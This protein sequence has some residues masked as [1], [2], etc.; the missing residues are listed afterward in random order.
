MSRV[1]VLFASS[2]GQTRAIAQAIGARLR[3]RGH[4]VE[5]AD[6]SCGLSCLPPPDDYDAVV[7]GS[8]VEIGKHAKDVV[9]YARRHRERLAAMPSAFFSVC[10]AAAGAT[11]ADPGGYLA[12]FAADSGW[13]APRAIAIAGALKYRRY[14]WLT[15]QVMRAIA[16]RGGHAT[17]TSRDHEYTDWA[18]V[19]AFADA[20]ADDLRAAVTPVPPPPSP[21]VRPPA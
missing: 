3:D 4:V 5:V 1:L 21:E 2:Y 9:A 6:S 20:V 8:R 17:D 19:D 15:R 13:R 14:G 10:M 12:R 16:K 18:Q 7:I 11:E